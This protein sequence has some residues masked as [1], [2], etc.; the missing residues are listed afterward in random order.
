MQ[1][2]L[3]TILSLKQFNALI[4]NLAT[5]G[6]MRTQHNSWDFWI[7]DIYTFGYFMFLYEIDIYI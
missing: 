6:E 2:T 7:T 1:W 3:F 5:V 4:M